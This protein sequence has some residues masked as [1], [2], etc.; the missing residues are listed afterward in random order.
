MNSRVHMHMKILFNGI[1]LRPWFIKDRG[2][3]INWPK[4]SD[5][6]DKGRKI[7]APIEVE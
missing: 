3:N 4:I 7:Y 2:L 1:V 5:I 6:M